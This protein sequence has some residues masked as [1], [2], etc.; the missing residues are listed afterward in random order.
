M[1]EEHI[2][3]RVSLQPTNQNTVFNHLDKNHR[4]FHK[5]SLKDSESKCESESRSESVLFQILRAVDKQYH[6]ECFK[7]TDCTNCLDGVPFTLDATNNV[8]CV[9]CYNK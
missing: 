7:C 8:L 5:I 2:K 4:L 3:E 6:P 9:Q 1:C